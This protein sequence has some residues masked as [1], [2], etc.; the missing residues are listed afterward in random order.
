MS[1]SAAAVVLTAP[2]PVA[3]IAPV[4]EP[5]QLNVRM[6]SEL[7]RKGDAALQKAGVSPS[8]ATRALWQRAA[9]L[10]STPE[11]IIELLFPERARE[12]EAA[13]EAERQRKIELARRGPL[14]MQEHF[15]KAGLP[16]PPTVEDIS[17]DELREE[18]YAERFGA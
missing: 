2:N 14:I 6:D 3:P 12:E 17:D 16:W 13:R 18:I 7:K 1:G 15:E 4:A 11:K 5:T 10:E 9:D 8:Q